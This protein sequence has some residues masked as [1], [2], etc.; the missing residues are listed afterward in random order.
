MLQGTSYP[1]QKDDNGSSSDEKDTQPP[2]ELL[3]ISQEISKPP[4]PVSIQRDP[5]RDN[6]SSLA[7]LPAG[8]EQRG[9]Q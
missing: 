2:P 1:S 8:Q 4:T 7:Q 3:I 9:L 5:E 6:E